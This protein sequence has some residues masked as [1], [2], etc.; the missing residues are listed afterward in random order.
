[1]MTRVR[2]SLR[3]RSS[4]ACGVSRNG[5]GRG[6]GK[7]QVGMTLVEMIIGISM[8]AVI[9]GPLTT[10]AI[11]FAQHG[12]EV[13]KSLTDD[14]SI[15]SISSMWVTD[16]QSASSVVLN[17]TSPCASKGTAAATLGWNDNGVAFTASWYAES[18]NQVLT[19]VRRRC[20][21]G[22]LVGYQ[23]VADIASPP[24][25][26]CAP[27]CVTFTSLTLKGNAANGAVYTLVGSKRTS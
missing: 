3:L 25:V 9:T 10:A 20:A 7:S 22:T 5:L 12:G 4:T 26:V 21:D 23:R 15:R 16:A 8:L 13:D 19:L 11:M 2:F 24:S 14:G 17:D 1:M 18:V 27:S 6:R